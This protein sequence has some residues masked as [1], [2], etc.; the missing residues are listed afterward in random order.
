M[1]ILVML[2][3]Q[4]SQ[5]PP[6]DIVVRGRRTSGAL[7]A[8]VAR[9]CPTPD[10]VRFSIAHAETQFAEG[11]YAE[12]RATLSAALSRQNRNARQF[13][14][15]VAALHEA[16]ATVNL[17][18]GDMDRYRTAI[19]GQARTLSEN[20]PEDDPQVLVTSL[21]VGD[22]WI[23]QGELQEARRHFGKASR[24][25]ARSGD[26]GLAA[27]SE[28]R[29]VAID[30][31]LRSFS[32]A[33]GRLDR[34]SLSSIA[35]DPSVRMVGAV[36][37]ARLEAARGKHVDIE[38]LLAFLRTGSGAPPLLV[39]A[40]RMPR[41]DA[42]EILKAR[43]SGTAI[44][45]ADIGFMVGADG[46]VGDVEVLRASRQQ[47]WIAPYLTEIADRRYAPVDL[48]AGHPG[49]YRVERYTFRADRIVPHGSHIKRAAGQPRVETIDMTNLGAPSRQE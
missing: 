18:L 22:F 10:D 13:P 26:A 12:A 6:A 16:M 5:E 23:K 1:L 17:H 4:V 20:L 45:W 9:A 29:M 38:A 24:I 46:R 31:A 39:K 41:H 8:C 7:E 40:G 35:S 34:I 14:R 2:L 44:Q 37:T 49:L 25:F 3:L 48:P 11:K 42:P 28:L 19:V 15:L 32:T 33:R 27:L 36:M 21:R 43:P 47:A 30:I